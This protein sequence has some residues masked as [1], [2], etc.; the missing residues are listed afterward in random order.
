M[1]MGLKIP[2]NKEFIRG[3]IDDFHCGY[4]PVVAYFICPVL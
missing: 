4:Y 3:A 2:Y 1:F